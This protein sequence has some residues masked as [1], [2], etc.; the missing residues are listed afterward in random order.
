MQ[1]F[2][3]IHISEYF[4]MLSLVF[5]YVS[6]IY[7]TT[8]YDCNCIHEKMPGLCCEVHESYAHF[9]VCAL[10]W[11]RKSKLFKKKKVFRQQVLYLRA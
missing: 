10:I 8:D 11:E 5:F 2:A 3:F 6:I 1:D 9:T 7:M 4:L